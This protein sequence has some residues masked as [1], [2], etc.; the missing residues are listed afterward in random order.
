M[1]GIALA[2]GIPT[3]WF[4]LMADRLR[5]PDDFCRSPGAMEGAGRRG[6]A[7]RRK[8]PSSDKPYNSSG[9]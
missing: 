4:E 9:G 5:T 2:S 3:S 7:I 6:E 1:I 8:P